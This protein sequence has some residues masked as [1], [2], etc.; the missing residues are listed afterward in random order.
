MCVRVKKTVRCE[1]ELARGGFVCLF[2]WGE[3]DFLLGGRENKAETVL[4]RQ[5]A[6]INV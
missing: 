3:G 6:K 2:S 5:D 4:E 1:G